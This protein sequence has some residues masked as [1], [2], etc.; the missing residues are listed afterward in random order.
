MH[1]IMNGSMPALHVVA[2]DQE[3]QDQRWF[4]YHLPVFSQWVFGCRIYPFESWV[5]ALAGASG[6]NEGFARR[7]QSV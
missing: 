7:F 3:E 4:R 5:A 2:K 6:G 1:R